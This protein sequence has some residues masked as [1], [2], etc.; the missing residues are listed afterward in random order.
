MA[1]RPDG[2]KSR[3]RQ[4]GV[5]MPQGIP[6]LER[7]LQGVWTY[8]RDSD[9]RWSLLRLPD[10]LGMT[11]G[12]LSQWRCDGILAAIRNQ[13]EVTALRTLD[14]PVVNMVWN[15]PTGFPSVVIDHARIGD[16]AAVFFLDHGY[17]MLGFYGVRGMAFSALR[18][19][20][21]R[22]SAQS[23]GIRVSTLEAHEE[24]AADW[25]AS[26]KRLG[27]WLAGL[28][29]PVGILC[30]NDQHA[31]DVLDACR[32][33]GLAIPNQ[34]AVLGVDNHQVFCTLSEP[35]LSSIARDDVRHGYQLASWLDRL[36]HGAA[37][38]PEPVLIPPLGIIERASTTP[39]GG[40]N[41]HLA[42]LLAFIEA[43]ITRPFPVSELLDRCELSR[44][45]AEQL[46]SRELGV[47]P[48]RFIHGRRIA[49]AKRL[50]V[51][52]AALPLT[53]VAAECGFTSLDQFRR[54]FVS[55][56]SVMPAA[57]RALFTAAKDP[58]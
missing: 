39:T 46:F 33:L 41:P 30:C 34:V 47:S 9:E 58:S 36:I 55:I 16:M 3:R 56:E 27:R 50:L 17:R 25:L 43:N 23:A 40:T 28:G 12:R 5:L 2:L 6:F 8:S 21:F 7:I 26:R 52:D 51:E 19:R 15:H 18:E 14:V 44:R 24:S 10:H 54:V 22:V 20:H 31:L 13:D 48:A 37:P 1:P 45:H 4:I 42:Q 11:A 57:Y 29:K 35:T 49:R 53:R 32:D 38:P